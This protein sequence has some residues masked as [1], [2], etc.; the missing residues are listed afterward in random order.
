MKDFKTLEKECLAILANNAI[1]TESGEYVKTDSVLI[2]V[3]KI[4]SYLI[5]QEQR[6]ECVD[7]GCLVDKHVAQCDV[8]RR[9]L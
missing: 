1:Q 8:C 3:G 6:H 5:H 7:C 4:V 9:E 2:A